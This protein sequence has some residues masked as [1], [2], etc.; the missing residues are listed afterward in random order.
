MN[1]N[2]MFTAMKLNSII[3]LFALSISVF[4]FPVAVQPGNSVAEVSLL[5]LDVCKGSGNGVMNVSDLPFIYEC[6]CMPI[7]TS[8]HGFFKPLS[9]PFNL[10]L[11]A[12]QKDY[13][14]EI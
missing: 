12:F 8:I 7:Q 11:I 10:P 6:P 2:K 3:L 9:S 4:S 5:T 13:P 1:S 14:P